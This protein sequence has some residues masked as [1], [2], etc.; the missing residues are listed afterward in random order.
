MAD[1]FHV[2]CHRQLTVLFSTLDPRHPTHRYI[3]PKAEFS[4]EDWPCPPLFDLGSNSKTNSTGDWF[5]T[6][7]NN[8]HGFNFPKGI[9]AHC[10][11][12]SSGEF[13]YSWPV[14][15]ANVGAGPGRTLF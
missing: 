7:N 15:R 6:L 9:A 4:P 2:L 14:L 11:K 12:L 1:D 3:F 8:E 13:G 5:C 10:D